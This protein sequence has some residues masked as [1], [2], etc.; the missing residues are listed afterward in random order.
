M[1]PDK[2]A[3]KI[4]FDTYWSSSGWKSAGTLGWTPQTPT[5]DYE[6]AVQAGVM[7]HARKITHEGTIDRILQLRARISPQRVGTAFLESLTSRRFGLRSALGSYAVALNMP[8]HRFAPS[9]DNVRCQVCGAYAAEGSN[10]NV[11][12]FERHKWGGVRHAQPAYIAFDLERFIVEADDPPTDYEPKLL[13]GLLAAVDSVGVGAK[14]SELVRAL[15]P[16]VPGNEAQRRTVV[17]I[18]GYAGIL[19]I[20]DRPGFF[21]SFPRLADRAETPW[22]K[23]DWP[24]PARWWRGGHGIDRQAVGFWFGRL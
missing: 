22:S 7:F 6:F 19:Q 9:S 18:L 15:K 16:V 11:L 10:D 20:A 14:L 4:L 13:D 24:Y 23:D 1:V 3:L 5:N 8:F 2:R 17:G 12:S 21:K